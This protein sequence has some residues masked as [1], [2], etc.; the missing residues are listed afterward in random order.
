MADLKP[1]LDPNLT[2]RCFLK[3]AGSGLAGFSLGR[4]FGPS[5]RAEAQIP[6]KGLIIARPSYFYTPL[7]KGAVRCELCPRHCRLPEGERGF[8]RVRENRGGRLMS[9]VYGNPCAFHLDPI[10]KNPFFHVLPG[11]SSLSL[12]TAGC[13]FQCKFCQ[14]WEISQASPEDVFGFDLPPDKAVDRAASMGARSMAYTFV[15][16]VIFYEYMADVGAEA[17]KAG[18]LSLI[19]S[20]GFINPAPLLQLVPVLD[21]ANIDLKGFSQEYYQEL[22]GG[23]LKPV[24]DTLI[25][26]KKENLHLEITNLVVPGKNDD[27]ALIGEMCRWI[28]RE[29][30]PDT[31]LHFARFY[32]LYKLKGLPPTPVA[33]LEKARA[34]AVSAGLKYVYL[35]GVPGHEAANTYCP[36][37]RKMIVRRLGFMIAENHLAEGRCRFCGHRIPGLWG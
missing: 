17:K 22:C 32:P 27:P 8:C 12:A 23:E 20:N 5:G 19:H 30:S 36:G 16:P 21:G 14:S 6:R 18:L 7:E 29:L 10:E 25:I 3:L 11:T 15:E 34:E 26:L 33:T 28:K 35:G 31:P 9:L 1:A 24:L 13:N 37:C 2:R 4:L